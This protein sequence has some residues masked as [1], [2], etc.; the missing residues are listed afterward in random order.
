[1]AVAPW[2]VFDYVDDLFVVAP[3]GDG[4][5]LRLVSARVVVAVAVANFR[6][7]WT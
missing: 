4:F 1:M 7:F 6:G 5:L 3:E 2:E